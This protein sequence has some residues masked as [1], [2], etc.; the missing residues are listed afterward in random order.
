MYLGVVT[1]AEKLALCSAFGVYLIFLKMRI[2]IC[3]IVAVML[4]GRLGTCQSVGLP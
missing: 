4:A 1:K 2:I 3:Y